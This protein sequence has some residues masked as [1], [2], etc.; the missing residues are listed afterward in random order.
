MSIGIL[1]DYLLLLEEDNRLLAHSARGDGIL[2]LK[3]H[4]VRIF[5]SS[6]INGPIAFIGLDFSHGQH[7]GIWEPEN[8]QNT[9]VP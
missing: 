5:I 8:E 7:L 2:T 1:L 3:L 6:G 9:N 4:Q